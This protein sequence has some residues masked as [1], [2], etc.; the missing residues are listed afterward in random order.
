M[1]STYRNYSSKELILES[2]AFENTSTNV[3]TF[4]ERVRAS[5]GQGREAA[6]IF[7]QHVN[8]FQNVD[9]AL[10]IG[11]IGPNTPAEVKQRRAQHGSYWDANGYFE[12]NS[13]IQLGKLI[14]K[15][16][17]VHSFYVHGGQDFID[18]SRK[19]SGVSTKFN[20][21]A[22]NSTDLLTHFIVERVLFILGEKSGGKG[23]DLIESYKKKYY[24]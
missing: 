4:L 10:I 18:I 13:E 8:K 2:T 11:D 14:A 1:I 24:K 7:L 19:T 16:I 20:V 17:P 22:A 9:Q 12:T 6:E 3:R 15:K 5:G 21:N 23:A